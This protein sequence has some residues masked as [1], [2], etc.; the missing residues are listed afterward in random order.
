MNGKTDTFCPWPFSSIAPKSFDKTG[1]LTAFWPCCMMGNN[2]NDPNVLKIKEDVSNLNPEE[3]FY[4]PRMQELRN[5]L[6]NGIRD[7]ACSV[8]WNM[9]DKGITSFRQDSNISKEIVSD[10]I[11][12][13]KLQVI[14]T[15]V[16]NSCN[17]Q[18]RMCDPS[19]SSQ[20]KKDT[21][22][23]IKHNLQ[24]SVIEALDNRWSTSG[25]GAW[26]ME[27][28][29]QWQWIK[30][31]TDKFKI[32]KLS[33]GEPFYNKHVLEFLDFAVKNG[34]SK[35]ITLEFHTNGTLF[36]NNLLDI[37]E[38]FQTNLNFSIDGYGK[39][40]EYIRYPMT[41]S[42]LD[43]SINRYIDRCKPEFVHISF[44][45]MIYNIFNIDK[46]AD[47]CYNLNTEVII[48]WAE[49]YPFNRGIVLK[50]LPTEILEKAKTIAENIKIDNKKLVN[51]IEDALKNN[52]ENKQKAL[53]E[54]SLFDKS[55]DQDFRNYLD[56][57]VIKWLTN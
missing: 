3:M 5:N 4:H 35:D 15:H 30:E 39:V 51:I 57:D 22:Y 21:N 41:W 28:V 36:D 13:P 17:L 23:F 50:H 26:R 29:K 34:N 12:N 42:Q 11:N 25:K 2:S 55:R 33:G 46:F 9:E 19:A 45:P 31:N 10:I 38:N 54:I 18:C 48:H 14:D 40:Y 44:I 56:Q 37:L 24:Y 32:L 43:E 20:L 49:V 47:W 16:N 53:L 8:C 52:A 1:K 7:N 6:K 27:D